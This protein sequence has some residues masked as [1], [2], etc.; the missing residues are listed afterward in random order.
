MRCSS[1]TRALT[2][3]LVRMRFA[4]SAYLSV[5]MVSSK[6]LAHGDT[7]PPPHERNKREHAQV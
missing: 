6:W 2:T 1:L 5:D 7:L 4:L 3:A